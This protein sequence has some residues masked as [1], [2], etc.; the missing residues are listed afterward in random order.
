MTYCNPIS[1]TC[2]GGQVRLLQ[3]VSR[4]ERPIMYTMPPLAHP[5]LHPGRPLR[6]LAS[7]L[8]TPGMPRTRKLL[9]TNFNKV[10]ATGL[11]MAMQHQVRNE[12]SP[13][14]A[15]ILTAII[16]AP[17]IG[18]TPHTQKQKRKFPQLSLRSRSFNAVPASRQTSLSAQG[19]LESGNRYAN[20]IDSFEVPSRPSISS[21]Q[22]APQLSSLDSQMTPPTPISRPSNGSLDNPELAFSNRQADQTNER[23]A[24]AF[25]KIRRKKKANEHLFPLP[26]RPFVTGTTEL[27]DRMQNDTMGPPQHPSFP[28]SSDSLPLI[29]QRTDRFSSLVDRDW[30]AP[31]MP[32]LPHSATAPPSRFPILRQ[33]SST[34]ARS[35]RSSPG[36]AFA[37]PRS[38]RGRSSTLSSNNEWLEDNPTDGP[39]WAGSGR[40]SMASATLDRNSVTGLR[41]LTSR[42][43]N[44]S[45]LTSP[46]RSRQVTPGAS[47]GPSNHNSF[48]ISRDQA[49]APPREEGETAG[50]YFTRIEKDIPKR[51]IALLMSRS[52]DPFSHDVLRSLM[53]TFKFFE[54]PMDMSIRRFLWEIALPAE[55]QQIDR[56][57][58]AFAERYHECNPHIFDN[59]GM[60]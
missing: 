38:F 21:S 2:C 54:D 45:E 11:Q 35:A 26:I 34:S 16:S 24:S 23:V 60:Y 40:S 19:P 36:L 57:I 18:M 15:H 25:F 30:N 39:A 50:K 20:H 33:G 7:R 4:V 48:A 6:Q 55:A 47:N 59:S 49:A 43:R 31:I 46:Q 13:P 27:P 52:G 1:Q 9:Y 17:T 51:S 12:I 5:C 3:D 10:P 56:V 41:S 53:R 42:F 8:S 44:T 32:G 22:G 37:R 14:V 28:H 58:A 29:S